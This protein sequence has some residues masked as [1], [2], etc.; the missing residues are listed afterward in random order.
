MTRRQFATFALDGQDYGIQVESVQEVLRHSVR[1][2]VPLAPEAIGGL[3][4]LRGQVVTAVDLRRRLGLPAFPA[5][6][7]P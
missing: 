2:P 6:R 1:T 4:N 5:T 7:T 3:I